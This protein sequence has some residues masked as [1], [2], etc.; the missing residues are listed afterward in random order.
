MLGRGCAAAERGVHN[1]NPFPVGLFQ[2]EIAG[3]DAGATNDPE[4]LGRL[5]NLFG[6]GGS[7]ADNK[8]IGFGDGLQ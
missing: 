5:K 7:A 1:N 6:D 4:L 8:C 2:V 3:A